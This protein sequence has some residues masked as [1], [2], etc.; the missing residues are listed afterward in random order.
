MSSTSIAFQWE[1][2]EGLKAMET[3]CIEGNGDL[4]YYAIINP[5]SP[6][7]PSPPPPPPPPFS[8]PPVPLSASLSFSTFLSHSLLLNSGKHSR[9]YAYCLLL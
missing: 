6:P 3:L 8:P 9:K 5:P 2:A 7:S 1:G 4:V